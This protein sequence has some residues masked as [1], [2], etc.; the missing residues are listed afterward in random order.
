MM[1]LKNLST[2]ALL[3][4][5]SVALVAGASTVDFSLIALQDESHVEEVPNEAE[6]IM[7]AH[8]DAEAE[9]FMHWDEEDPPEVPTSCARCHSSPGYMDFIGA[10]GT[11]AGSVENPAPI[12]TVIEC[13]TCHNEAAAA[14]DS[15]VMPS[16][17]EITGLGSEARCM[18][19]HQGR[20][21][22][23]TVDEAIADANVPDLDAVMP[24]ARFI[25]IHY[26]A[27]AATRLGG[28]ALGGY[29][30]DDPSYDV[31]FAHVSGVDE[32]VDCHDSHSLQIKGNLCAACHPGVE[33]VE[34]VKNVRMAGS[35]FDYDGDGNTTEGIYHEVTGLRESLYA[36]MQAY[37]VG[38]GAPIAYDPNAYPYFFADD[39][40]NGVVDEGEGSYASWTPR[41][42]KAAYNYHTPLKDPGAFAHNA[43]YI[44]QLLHDSIADL[45]PDTAAT[46]VRNDAGH[47]A[48]SEEP[49]R[50]W[51]EEGEVPGTCSKCHSATGLPF[52]LEEGVTIGQPPSNGLMCETCHDAIPQFT[53]RPVEEV[54]FPSGA[55][56]STD[57]PDS[58]LC[59]NCHQ[60]RESTVSVNAYIAAAGAT[61]EDEV[62]GLSFRNVHYYAAGATYFGT[63]AKGAYEYQGKTYLGRLDHVRS[64]DTCAECHDA[65]SGAVQ[66][67][68]CGNLFCHGTPDVTGIREDNRDFDG[69]GITAEGLAWE[70]NT[71]QEVLYST[72]RDYAANVAGTPIAYSGRAYPYFF[73]DT[74]NN[75]QV[76]EGEGRF[77][78]W[79]PRLV[80]ATYNY[81]YVQKDPGA[82]AHNGQYII[83]V[84]HD[85]IA[86]LGTKVT[87]DQSKMI[88]P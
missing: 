71:F 35:A 46:L 88:R 77:S 65:H 41:M 31:K 64:F 78:S 59:I 49:W 11:P 15:V 81:Q 4:I 10:D 6:W 69:D 48:G 39:N 84:L 37:G 47:F 18:Q 57:D 24:D 17:I 25:N 8:A 32:C 45:A 9:A 36:A 22:K 87:V 73:V 68:A 29:Q 13:I 12:G 5:A 86:D 66:T 3:V 63:Q 20:A 58:N 52:L 42:L 54:E 30:Y 51:D 1:M 62:G 75:G 80:K 21:S 33:T 50:H 76:D 72:I 43:K 27:A 83:Q 19:C 79:T 23:L 7:S 34:D 60:G 26:Y 74:N 61:D 28:L 53:R 14:L 40:G 55:Q 56:L 44:I 82:F 38:I 2:A 67:Q 85:T 16:G 70:V